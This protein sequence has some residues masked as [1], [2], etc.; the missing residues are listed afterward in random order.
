MLLVTNIFHIREKKH[1]FKI[2]EIR[3]IKE[4]QNFKYYIGNGI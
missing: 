2:K 4:N 1:E 3:E